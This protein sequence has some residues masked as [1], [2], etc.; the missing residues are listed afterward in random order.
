MLE[1]KLKRA[2]ARQTAADDLVGSALDDPP[3]EITVNENENENENDEDQDELAEEEAVEEEEDTD[4]DDQD[5]LDDKYH[6]PDAEAELADLLRM[7]G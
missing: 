5:I 2:G 7:K 6:D 1:E 4:G 3:A